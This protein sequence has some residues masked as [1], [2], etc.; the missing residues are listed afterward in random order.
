MMIDHWDFLESME[1]NSMIINVFAENN[2]LILL[3]NQSIE[4]LL[5]AK[6]SFQCY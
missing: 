6:I 1:E 2:E 5:Q 4:S 3:M